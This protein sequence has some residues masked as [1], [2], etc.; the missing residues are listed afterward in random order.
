M[1]YVTPKNLILEKRGPRRTGPTL[2]NSTKLYKTLQ[3]STK[4][5]KTL[6]NSTK[7]YKTLQNS[8]K[9]Y[10]TLQNSTKLYKTLQNSTNENFQCFIDHDNLSYNVKH[11][12]HVGKYA[13]TQKKFDFCPSSPCLSPKLHNQKS[14]GYHT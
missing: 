3:N 10:K 4:L 8:T 6:Q 14:R 12:A 11:L 7:L 9:L 1:N 5:Y 13:D 2:Q